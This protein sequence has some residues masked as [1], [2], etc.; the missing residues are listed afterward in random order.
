MLAGARRT[1][2][3]SMLIACVIGTRRGQAKKIRAHAQPWAAASSVTNRRQRR[4]QAENVVD[5]ALTPDRDQKTR[6]QMKRHNF[7]VFNVLCFRLFKM[8]PECSFTSVCSQ[9]S[10]WFLLQPTFTT[11]AFFFE[12]AAAADLS[13]TISEALQLNANGGQYRACP[14]L[15]YSLPLALDRPSAARAICST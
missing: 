14:A 9:M 10:K 15:R 3:E 8:K 4:R 11:E 12:S 5:T 7:L 13:I 6:E 2:D 1:L